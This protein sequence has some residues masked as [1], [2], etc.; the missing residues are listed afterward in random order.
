MSTSV[1]TK[2]VIA[3]DLNFRGEMMIIYLTDGR[4]LAIPLKWF[5]TL[6]KASKVELTN[7]RF[8][9]GGRGIHW[10]ALDEDIL[11]ENLIL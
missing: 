6:M 3:R 10:E 11:V 8:I 2:S 7:W 1:I 9:S 5:P 4:E